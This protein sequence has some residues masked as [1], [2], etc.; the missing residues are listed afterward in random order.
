MH[1]SPIVRA[2]APHAR[3]HHQGHISRDLA[4]KK[5]RADTGLRAAEARRVMSIAHAAVAMGDL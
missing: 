5:F 4:I 3:Q 2:A 1:I